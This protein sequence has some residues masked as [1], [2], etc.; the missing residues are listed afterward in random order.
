MHILYTFNNRRKSEESIKKKSI[1][2]NL[3][4]QQQRVYQTNRYSENS[5]RIKWPFFVLI[6]HN[7]KSV[8]IVSGM[9][10]KNPN[11]KIQQCVIG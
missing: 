8:Q 10:H 7:A 2:L 11:S 4:G 5:A 1:K 3:L 6:L 9:R